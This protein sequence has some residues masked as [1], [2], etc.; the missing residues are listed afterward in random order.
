[1]ADEANL[2][3][4]GVEAIAEMFAD[5]FNVDRNKAILPD[6]PGEGHNQVEVRND[7]PIGGS[8]VAET[9]PAVKEESQNEVPAEVADLPTDEEEAAL[10]ESEQDDEEDD[11]ENLEETAQ[12]V[13]RKRNRRP[14]N[15]RIREL[16]TRAKQA[17]AEV[18]RQR[19]ET[20]ALQQQMQQMQVYLQQM[21]YQQQLPQQQVP[22][23]SP[24]DDVDR[25]VDHRFQQQFSPYQQEI[26][27]LKL[28]LEQ[29]QRAQ[30]AAEDKARRDGLK[31]QLDR[32][33]TSAVEEQ[34]LGLVGDD[35][36]EQLRDSA[37]ELSM[38]MSLIFGEEAPDATGRLYD[39]LENYRVS[40]NRALKGAAAKKL[41]A[42]KSVPKPV[43]NPKA[44]IK[45][46]S[47]GGVQIPKNWSDYYDSPFDGFEDGWR[48]VPQGN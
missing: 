18:Q 6:M 47:E 14:A 25:Y 27:G 1:M 46:A 31:A 32:D 34:I 15:E 38:N 28:Q 20:A 35:D 21:Q 3:L 5:E 33:V 9:E 16:N 7:S 44:A 24:E 45:S 39:F 10:Q 40:R 37:K 29:F 17:E 23:P 2:E 11:T 8:E 48:K 43:A 19:Q 41:K 22:A 12:V 42:S 30:K 26:E 36:R 4:G 13:Q